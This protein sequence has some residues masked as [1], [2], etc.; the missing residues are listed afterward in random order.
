MIPASLSNRPARG[1]A[2][3][4]LV[5]GLAGCLGGNEHAP[6]PARPSIQSFTAS[7]STVAL[8]GSTVL[9]WSVTG[10]DTVSIAP[11][12]GQVTGT[13][14][15]IRPVATTTF[16]LSATNAGGTATTSATVTIG[17]PPAGLSYVMNP[18]TYPAGLAVVPNLPFS[19]GGAITAYDVSPD[20]PTGLSIHP[21]TG[22]LTG[23]PAEETATATYTVT[24]SNAVGTTSVALVLTVGPPPPPTISAFTATPPSVAAGGSSVL[25]W[26]VTGATTLSIDH[27]VG[28]V[29]G[30]SVT[31]TPTAATT[32][33]L[34]ATNSGGTSTADVTVQVTGAPTNVRYATNPA[35]YLAGVAIAA[36]APAWDGGTP[37]SFAGTVPPGLAL[38]PTSGVVSG[39]PTTIAPATGYTITASNATGSATVVL[40]VTVSEAV[41]PPT[42]LVYAQNPAVYTVGTP[43]SPNVAANSGGAIAEYAVSPTTPLPAGLTLDAASGVLTGT[44]SAVTPRT[45]CTIT[46]RNAAGSTSVDLVLTVND[47]VLAIV[48]QPANQSALP[49]GT[50]T[51]SVV[52]SGVGLHYQWKKDGTTDVGTDAASFTTPVLTAAD[53]GTT[54]GVVVT[55]GSGSVTSRDAVLSLRGFFPLAARMTDA[56]Y[57]HTATLL[58]DGRV[59][60]AGGNVRGAG[61]SAIAQIYDPATRT[62]ARTA[63]DMGSPRQGHA[64]VKLRDGRVLIA[65]GCRAGA[66]LC[67]Q[68]WDTIEIFDPATDRFL[69]PAPTARMSTPRMYLAAALLPG[70][71]GR[72]LLAGGYVNGTTLTASADLFVPDPGPGSGTIVATTPMSTPRG[73]PAS[74][75]LTAD[76]TVLVAGGQAVVD[77]I[78]V[79]LATAEKY[80]L[81]IGDP[82]SAGV[83]TAT[84]ALSGGRSNG[85]ATPPEDG[86]AEPVLLSGGTGSGMRPTNPAGAVPGLLGVQRFDGSAFATTGPLVVE[87]NWQT[88]TRLAGTGEVLVT[89]GNSSATYLASAEIHD[90]VAEVSTLVPPMGTPRAQ[91]TATL[92]LDGTV[93]VAGGRT[94]AVGSVGT[95]LDSAEVWAP[96]PY[97]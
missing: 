58:D 2:A 68:F 24:G 93:L 83:F 63:N 38:D 52:A 70:A 51:F 56:V 49:G 47:P 21:T 31:V 18:V 88:A 92:L 35:S 1:V 57:G 72:V 45:T 55:D 95:T 3:L 64:A 43:I 78:P 6:T 89:G 87:R 14:I 74:A 69:T 16:V 34:S 71:D 79:A 44:P 12:I 66:I 22:I 61:S 23:T 54:Y 76:G 59:L 80:R 17:D 7:P 81:A 29:T 77:N 28:T 13:S 94:G 42:N 39:T 46:G 96:Y 50:A 65:G 26:T 75:T 32:Y 41:L 4:A 53:D 19:T 40:V 85:V 60:L 33:R 84:G 37:T 36:N 67:T 25:A 90:P 91:H 20:L 97:P 27:G 8:G 30:T 73:Y 9:S 11:G 48:T 15:T 62:F 10:A 86:S 82:P 5:A